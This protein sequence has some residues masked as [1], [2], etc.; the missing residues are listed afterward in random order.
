MIVKEFFHFV[1]QGK[2]FD[3]A[4]LPVELLARLDREIGSV[5]Y[6]IIRPINDDEKRWDFIPFVAS[7]KKELTK[8]GVTDVVFYNTL[9]YD[10]QCNF[11]YGKKEMAALY[12]L[13]AVLAPST[14]RAGS[15]LIE[16]MFIDDINSDG[17]SIVEHLLKVIIEEYNLTDAVCRYEEHEV[18]M[19]FL[20]TSELSREE[21]FSLGQKY[22]S[23]VY[24]N[25][26]NF[27]KMMENMRK[28]PSMYLSKSTLT[29]LHS[30]LSGYVLSNHTESFAY[31]NDFVGAYYGK[32]S[33]AGWYNLI[34]AD[35][36]GNEAEAWTTFFELYDAFFAIT[37]DN[38]TINSRE[39]LH[40]LLYNTLTDIRFQSHGKDD[41]TIFILT[42]WLHN[43]PLKL[44]N[45]SKH[46]IQPSYDIILQEIFEDTDKNKGLQNLLLNNFE[47]L[48][49]CR[50]EIWKSETSSS[51]LPFDH[52]QKEMI[53]E[54]ET[55]S[56]TFL[57]MS[58]EKAQAI[59]NE[60]MGF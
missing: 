3:V 10:N 23:Y 16:L 48:K 9:A 43:L 31:F 27:R 4:N 21:I 60:K 36:Y 30:F 25:K 26:L 45:A 56:E 59:F 44:L 11:E 41:K 32:Y 28:R 51:L 39:I 57:A 58:F 24:F 1:L 47:E 13:R 54:K 38:P 2:K 12:K 18:N 42:N 52:A 7:F 40:K 50:Y 53:T 17:E 15:G 46:P 22:I 20:E 35:H 29:N 19:W 34:L 49:T 8:I 37:T 6:A 5:D 55:L 14:Y 33:T